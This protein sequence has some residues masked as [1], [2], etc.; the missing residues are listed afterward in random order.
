MRKTLL[1]AAAVGALLAA[2][3]AF[4]GAPNVVVSIKPLHSLVASVMA[5]VGEPKLIVDGVGSPH[6][7]SMKPSNA[8]DLAQADLVF[9]AGD[10][11]EAFLVK[12][13]ETLGGKATVVELIETPGLTKLKF[14]EGGP[15]E[16]HTHAG[17]GHEAGH[18]EHEEHEAA[19]AGKDDHDHD[20]DE[21]GGFD[22]HFWL[23]PLNA[24][25]LTAEIEKRLAAADP[26]NASIYEANA[27]KLDARLDAL[28]EKTK[29]EVA[30]VKDKPFIVFHDAYQ[31][32]ENR[33]GL[34]AAGSITVSPETM[35]GAQRVAAIKQKVSDLGATCVFAEPQFEPKLISVVTEGTKAHTGTLD[36]EG[37]ALANGPDLYF[38][39]IDGLSSSLKACLSQPS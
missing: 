18:E 8:S 2:A 3:P 19:E 1:S 39:L 14:R 4:A 17:E 28:M 34:R 38:Q 12:P 33:F 5:G 35:P 21:H 15:F 27:E 26:E 6:T 11:L 9:W 29:A 30:P 37:A 23:D 36:P 10:H 20:H 31:Y 7:Y 32:F 22:M 13:L 25:A 24:K 16:A